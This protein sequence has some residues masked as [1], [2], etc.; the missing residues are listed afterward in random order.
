MKNR[1]MLSALLAT[2]IF[3]TMFPPVP[4]I[5]EEDGEAVNVQPVVEEVTPAPINA[6]SE[7]E[8]AIKGGKEGV[9]YEWQED[10][11]IVMS[12]EK[13]TLSNVYKKINLVI[14]RGVNARIVFDNVS[15]NSI[16]LP[17]GASLTVDSSNGFSVSSVN[18]KSNLQ[19]N[20]IIN[21]GGMSF[22]EIYV[23]NLTINN[24]DF[25][26]VYRFTG[27][28]IRKSKIA[29]KTCIINNGIFGDAS[30]LW[31]GAGPDWEE[32]TPLIDAESIEIKGG[33][34]A[35]GDLANGTV[36]GSPIDEGKAI[37]VD[38]VGNQS[39]YKVVDKSEINRFNVLGTGYS[40]E[41]QVLKLN[42]NA[43]VTVSSNGTVNDCIVVGDEGEPVQATLTL[44]GVKMFGRR[45]MINVENGSSLT[46]ILADG[47]KNNLECM[48]ANGPMVVNVSDQSILTI[49]GKGDLNIQTSYNGTGIGGYG[50]V[51]VEDGN[52]TV[53]GGGSDGAAIGDKE[54]TINI[55]GGNIN[56]LGD[57]N[58]FGG[59]GIGGEFAKV[60][61]S[62]GN[63]DAQGGWMGAALGGTGRGGSVKIDGGTIK[64]VSYEDAPAICSNDVEINGG[65]ISAQGGNAAITSCFNGRIAIN[66]GTIY[67]KL[68]ENALNACI[69]GENVGMVTISNGTVVTSGG[70]RGIGSSAGGGDTIFSTG[71][72]TPVI[73]TN[74]ISD[75][76]SESVWNGV[77]IVDNM[78]GG[79][80]KIYGNKVT[81][82]ND[83]TIPAGKT[84][85]VDA[86]QSLV[87]AKGI[88]ATNNGT[89]IRDKNG[90]VDVQGTWLG[91]PV[92]VKGEEEG[93]AVT[94]VTLNKRT[95]ALKPGEN[96]ILMVTVSPVTAANK[97]LRWT[98]SNTDVATVDAN[99]RVTAM[100]NGMAVITVSTVDGGFTAQCTVTI[101]EKQTEVVAVENVKLNKTSLTLDIGESESLTATVTPEDAA[102]KNM[103]WSSNDEDVAS[104]DAKGKVTA[105]SR[106]TAT[107]TVRTEDGN[108][109]AQCKVTVTDPNATTTD[110]ETQPDGSTV[111]TVEDV[112]GSNSSTTVDVDGVVDTS[113]TLSDSA[114]SDAAKNDTAVILPMVGVKASKDIA[115]APSVTVDLPGNDPVQVEIPVLDMTPST[116]AVLVDKNGSET[117][118]KNSV[119]GNNG[120]IVT[121][122]DGETVKILDNTQSFS[123]VASN[124]WA[125]NN[126]DYVTSRGLFVGTSASEFAPETPM[127]RAMIVSVLQR[128]EGDDTVAAPGEDW[129]EGARQWAIK[130]DISDG[131]N[132]LSNVT[133]EQLVTMLYRYIGSPQVVGGLNSYSD[134]SSVSGY[135]EQAMVWA[136]RNGI[137]GG[138][139][140]DTLVPQ[141]IATRAQVAA[142]LQRFIAWE[143]TA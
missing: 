127:T 89:V 6:K 98:S 75:Q 36:F 69:G 34:F 20:L 143:Q 102:N 77:F 134:V 96:E 113:V 133:R 120:L 129:Y 137:I 103:T 116:V 49:K 54:M 48:D 105:I 1:K 111:T 107:I 74:S 59:T 81:P 90:V 109:A 66:G 31:E 101:S 9:D 4:A 119:L 30:G 58:Y 84:L 114:V 110:T 37:T 8:I 45:A 125:K 64:A 25:R 26:G 47:S 122:S 35:R 141:G 87:I 140:D 126:I 43:N 85:E 60:Y 121:L 61:I 44:N 112:N 10:T 14:N 118:L 72:G 68:H 57:S 91:N 3:C 94:G 39:Y 32:D 23:D 50:T 21:S 136:V 53:T 128:Y 38:V 117:I 33:L 29:A 83:F 56:A 130:A 92:T 115:S 12:D 100:A 42:Q 19:G 52:V 76:N 88:T 138:M 40:Y 97:S 106:G 123:D 41:K 16:D 11:L 63:I 104:V 15:L 70:A 124:H 46:L 108:F 51:S 95:L 142:I 86:D 71:E 93:S 82:T 62:G 139:T 5:A 28:D 7:E 2:T 13:L 55:S 67:A 27:V 80:G 135:A 132:M 131:S 65:S 73:I 79:V 17:N 18:G 99:G 22:G 78:N 24:G